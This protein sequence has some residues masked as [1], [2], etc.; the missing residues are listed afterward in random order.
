[1]L[2]LSAQNRT[3]YKKSANAGYLAA[4]APA[5]KHAQPGFVQGRGTRQAAAPSPQLPSSRRRTRGL[6]ALPFPPLPGAGG[7]SRAR[8]SRAGAGPAPQDPGQAASGAR[9]RLPGAPPA[10]PRLLTG[11]ARL[12]EE[13]WGGAPA[14]PGPAPHRGLT[15]RHAAGPRRL[16][17]AP[18]NEGRAGPGGDSETRPR[19]Q[20]S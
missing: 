1:M 2:L 17:S 5:D 15:R 16:P 13:E 18:P 11:P 19:P 14:R 6:L 20:G 7:A 3:L 4:K 9:P 8:K 10:A 12:L